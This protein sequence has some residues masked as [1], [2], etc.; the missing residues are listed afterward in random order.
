QLVD[1]AHDRAHDLRRRGDDQRVRGRIGPDGRV[2]LGQRLRV[3][4]R[5]LGAPAACA[6]VYSELMTRTISAAEAFCS[7]VISMS[8]S[9]TWSMRRMMR[10]IRLT[11]LARYD[12]MVRFE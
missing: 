11:L 7:G 12:R 3:G 4:L 5:S 1:D 6:P 8:W 10:T 2:L 9:P